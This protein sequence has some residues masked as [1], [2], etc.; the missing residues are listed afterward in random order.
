MEGPVIDTT[1][2]GY[3]GDLNELGSPGFLELA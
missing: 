2:W 1:V 3:T